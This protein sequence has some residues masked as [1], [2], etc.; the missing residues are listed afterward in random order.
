MKPFQIPSHQKHSCGS[1]TLFDHNRDNWRDYGVSGL[2]KDNYFL[3]VLL[4]AF[5]FHDPP[6]RGTMDTCFCCRL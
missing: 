3:F 2:D 1:R 6:H 5:I 4:H